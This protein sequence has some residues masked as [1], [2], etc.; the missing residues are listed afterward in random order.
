MALSKLPLRNKTV[1][2]D[3]AK[4][5]RILPALD[6]VAKCILKFL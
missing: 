4:F 2:F 3:S 6:Y 1:N 5:H